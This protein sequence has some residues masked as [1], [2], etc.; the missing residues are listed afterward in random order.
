MSA[1][2]AAGKS[3]MG[4]SATVRGSTFASGVAGTAAVEKNPF[5]LPSDV[6]VFSLREQ[7]RTQRDEVRRRARP[8]PTMHGARPRRPIPSRAPRTIV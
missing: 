8:H 5:V 7:E 1:L 2:T 3:L 4:D 6:D